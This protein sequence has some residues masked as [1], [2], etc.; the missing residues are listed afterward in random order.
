MFC[1]WVKLVV[2]CECNGTLI[3]TMKR[4]WCEDWST[5]LGVKISKPNNVLQCIRHSDVLGFRR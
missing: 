4:S 1:S 5:N 3:V 2:E